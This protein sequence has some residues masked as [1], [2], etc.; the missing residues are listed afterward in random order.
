MEWI[1]NE[2]LISIDEQLGQ[3]GGSLSNFEEMPQPVELTPEQQLARTFAEEYFDPNSMS[4]ILSKLKPE[5]NDGQSNL[6]EEIYQSVHG[7]GSKKAFVVSSPG[8]FG[9]TFAFQVLAAQVRSEGGIVLNVASTGL[10]AQ[11]L[12][13]GCTAHSRFK[14]PIPI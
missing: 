7:E 8:G 2:V 14:I 4:Q 3:M 9:K 10:A 6:C 13:G 12:L 5:L 11:N 1:Y